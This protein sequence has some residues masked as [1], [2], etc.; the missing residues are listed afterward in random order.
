M[1]ILLVLP[2]NFL[3][4]YEPT[5][6]PVGMGYISACL[7]ADGHSVYILNMNFENRPLHELLA[8]MIDQNNIEIV[9]TGGLVTHYQLVKEVV[10]TVKQLDS[11]IYT[12]IG[13]G[14]VTGAPKI[15]MQGI[16]NADFGIYGEGELTNCELVKAL[17]QKLPLHA[18]DGLIFREMKDGKSTLI[19]NKSRKEI[20]NLDDLPWPDY[21]GFALDKMLE[22]APKRY[23]TMSTGRSCAFN[24]T[25]CF[26]SSGQKY[27]QRSLDSFFTELDFL[28]DAYSIDNIYITDELF[29]YDEKR[30]NEFCDRIKNYNILWAIQLRVNIVN[31]KMLKLLKDTGCIIISFGL[32]SADN[33]ILKSMN[34]KITIADI[35][36][37][38]CHSYD[39]GISAHGG[40]IFGDIEEDIDSVETTINWWKS[41]KQYNIGL[42][43]IQIYP[44]TY[45]YKYACAKGIIADE[46][47]FIEDG[48]PYVNIS[49]LSDA[50]YHKLSI[51][52]EELQSDNKNE[53]DH[54]HIVSS[55]IKQRKITVSG[56]CK[57][58]GAENLIEKI[59]SVRITNSLCTSCSDGFSIHP[60]IL[61]H[62]TVE[63]NLKQ[64]FKD[65]VKIAFWQAN[66][67]LSSLINHFNFIKDED[68][69]I[70]DPSNIKQGTLFHDIPVHSPTSINET[71]DTVIIC[72]YVRDTFIK[73]HI[74]SDFKNIKRA[75]G[76]WDL[77]SDNEK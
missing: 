13:G 74:D 21:E 10:D 31:K 47:K 46:L 50:Q 59:S 35:E 19:Q 23:V 5:H 76:M 30:L 24:C 22:Y 71:I 44:G 37:A 69:I 14:L 26:H 6:F 70:V 60:S 34:K 42:D 15:V 40:F 3:N 64:L 25:F 11:T 72:D 54:L 45:L 18:I 49:K 39:I 29:A 62:E 1:N 7:K 12:L 57:I 67:I 8:A 38:L 77:L 20:E 27:R 56:N 2:K 66:N 58:C 28:V 53:L 55:D 9:E 43:L 52:L 16:Q 32:E 17:N 4:I 73:N 63:N 33:K 75:V 41:H 65:N 51:Q 36:Q 68:F 48:C 61:Y